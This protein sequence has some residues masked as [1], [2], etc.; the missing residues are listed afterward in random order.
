MSR[1]GGTAAAWVLVA[2]SAPRR[3]VTLQMLSLLGPPVF[4]K[5]DLRACEK[6]FAGGALAVWI[7]ISRID[8]M[9]PKII[10]VWPLSDYYAT[11]GPPI[12]SDADFI[13][14]R[15]HATAYYSGPL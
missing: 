12:P 7:P 8:G 15:D 10:V 6:A 9:S 2:S 14:A 11:G 13:C 1:S 3:D 5:I 4:A